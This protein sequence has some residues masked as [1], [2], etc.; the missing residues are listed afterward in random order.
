M[1]AIAPRRRR[2]IGEPVR[3]P[4]WQVSQSTAEAV[5]R[6]VEAGEAE[7]QNALVE[8]AILRELQELRRKRV[9]DAYAQAAADASFLAYMKSITETF[10]ATA[11]DGLNI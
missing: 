4:G 3:K 2:S 11:I 5:R 1:R 10:E 9:Y 6:A 8:R 7:S